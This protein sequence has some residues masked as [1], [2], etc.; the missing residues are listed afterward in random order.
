MTHYIELRNL[1]IK[2]SVDTAPTAQKKL[3]NN[4]YDQKKTIFKTDLINHYKAEKTQKIIENLHSI[5][6][7]DTQDEGEKLIETMF[8]EKQSSSYLFIVIGLLLFA[9]LLKFNVLAGEPITG[10]GTL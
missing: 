7:M 8:G 6:I 4:L 2:K 9:L 5:G 1:F 10:S 3:A